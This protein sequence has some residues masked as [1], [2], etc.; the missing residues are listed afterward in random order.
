ME[1]VLNWILKAWTWVCGGLN[2]I[3]SNTGFWQ[4]VYNIADF[5]GIVLG[6]L[7]SVIAIVTFFGSYYFKRIKILGWHQSASIYDGYKFGVSIQNRS[8]SALAIKR[9]SVILDN[10]E[11]VVLF[12]SATLPEDDHTKAIRSIEPFKTDV[13]TSS[14]STTPLFEKK[15]FVNYKRIVFCFTYADESQTKVRYKLRK[16]K[17]SKYKTLIPKQIV[18]RNVR[19]TEHMMYIVERTNTARPSTQHIVF[20]NGMLDSEIGIVSQ[21]PAEHCNSA[22]AVKLYLENCNQGMTFDVFKNPHNKQD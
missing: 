2:A 9:V 12:S 21:I 5:I 13:F 7:V 11:E 14:G 20:K 3:V 8:L 19:L 17:K 6:V 16:V 10:V 18:F 1:N 15:Q 4:V 22:D